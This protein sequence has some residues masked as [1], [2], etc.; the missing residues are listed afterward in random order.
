MHVGVPL[1]VDRD[2]RATHC[3][4]SCAVGSGHGAKSDQSDA[5]HLLSGVTHSRKCKH[6]VISGNGKRH[7]EKP[8]GDCWAGEHIRRSFSSSV[9]KS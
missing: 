7:K 6:A 9:R 4:P 3:V 8:P 1:P 2:S 5:R